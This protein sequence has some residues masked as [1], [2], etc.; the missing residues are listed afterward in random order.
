MYT[1]SELANQI[2]SVAR[3]AQRSATYFAPGRNEIKSAR[4]P[5]N[6]VPSAIATRYGLE[7][8]SAGTCPPRRSHSKD[9]S[10][11]DNRNGDHR[12]A[13]PTEK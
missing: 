10:V 8:P 12:I 4:N 1:G 6:A 5:Y 3:K 2:P 9:A 11:R 13:G 7:K